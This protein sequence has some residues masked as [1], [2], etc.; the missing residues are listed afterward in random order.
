MKGLR[1]KTCASVYDFLKHNVREEVWA[2]TRPTSRRQRSS[3]AAPTSSRSA[4]LPSPTMSHSSS[5]PCREVRPMSDETTGAEIVREIK[6]RRGKTTWLLS[7]D[8]RRE[9][10][11][12]SRPDFSGRR[13][14]YV[15]KVTYRL[16]PKPCPD[17]DREGLRW[18][19]AELERERTIA[20]RYSRDAAHGMAVH[21]AAVGSIQR[22]AF[23]P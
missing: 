11:V 18:Y 20:V 10:C 6:E 7:L 16:L 12:H 2:T 13:G 5:R 15:T 21:D 1:L 9:F 22:G 19:T 3:T 8:R 14:Q 23:N 4:P 17:D